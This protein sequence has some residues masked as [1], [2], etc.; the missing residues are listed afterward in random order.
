VKNEKLKEIEK[1]KKAQVTY[2]AKIKDLEAQIEMLKSS[3]G[4]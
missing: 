4:D 1:A 2:E 3:S